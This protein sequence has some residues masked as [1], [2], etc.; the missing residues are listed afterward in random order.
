MTE[1]RSPKTEYLRNAERCAALA[2][3]AED[4]QLRNL[5]R[6]LV[7]QWQDI[8]EQAEHLE[9]TAHELEAEMIK[10]EARQSRSEPPQ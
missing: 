3:K 9:K 7:G 2:A 10:L 8:A 5:Y 1:V 6:N 4:L